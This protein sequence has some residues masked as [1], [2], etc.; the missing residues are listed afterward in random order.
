M[1]A[2]FV[3]EAVNTR[4]KYYAPPELLEHVMQMV[5]KYVPLDQVTE[6]VEPAA[7][8]GAFMPYLNPLAKQLGVKVL[9]YDLEPDNDSI[10]KQDFLN[11]NPM[12]Y[13]PGRLII[14]GP[15]YGTGSYL[16]EAFERK[17]ESEE[18]KN[19]L[20]NVYNDIEQALANIKKIIDNE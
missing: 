10:P 2:R 19:N 11:D 5:K 9:Y 4:D 7:G 18:L 8:D 6:I 3:F 16:W 1:R 14:T 15:P 20:I 12:K 13:K 17:E